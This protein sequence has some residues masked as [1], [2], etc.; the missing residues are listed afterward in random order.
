MTGSLPKRLPGEALDA[1]VPA[2][3]PPAAVNLFD[4]ASGEVVPRR[5]FAASSR[6]HRVRVVGEPSGPRGDDAA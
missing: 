1:I 3:S 4:V 2:P 5:R 6:M